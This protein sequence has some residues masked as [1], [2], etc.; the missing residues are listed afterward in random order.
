MFVNSINYCGY[1][2]GQ[3]CQRQMKVQNNFLK[4]KICEYL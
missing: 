3:D 2:N 4:A 1:D